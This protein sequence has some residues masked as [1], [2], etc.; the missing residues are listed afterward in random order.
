[1]RDYDRSHVKSADI[2]R[3]A[4]PQQLLVPRIEVI[5]S[6]KLHAQR[7]RKRDGEKERKE[8]RQSYLFWRR[9]RP[10]KRQSQRAHRERVAKARIAPPR[11]IKQRLRR[12]ESLLD[13]RST[14][15][16]VVNCYTSSNVSLKHTT[17]IDKGSPLKCLE[18]ILTPCCALV[19]TRL[20]VG[21]LYR[22]KQ[23]D[24]KESCILVGECMVTRGREGATG[25]RAVAKEA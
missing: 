3:P 18:R 11:F 20:R 5:S 6:A 25:E 19:A 12:E 9:E 1:M 2:L 15:S 8:A 21:K 4:T 16:V 22:N 7:A 23:R 17:R 10:P 13:R 14:Q 24:V